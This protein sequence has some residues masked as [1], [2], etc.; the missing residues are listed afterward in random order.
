MRD[1]LLNHHDVVDDVRSVVRDFV[2]FASASS[3]CR[4]VR[5]PCLLHLRCQSL[6][7]TS[8]IRLNSMLFLKVS[9]PLIE[10]PPPVLRS[11]LSTSAARTHAGRSRRLAL[12]LTA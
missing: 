5:L 10:T 4:S 6:P 11:T 3:A 2:W 7:W 9:R 8:G 1:L 12:N